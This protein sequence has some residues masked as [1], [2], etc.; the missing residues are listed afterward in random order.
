[1]KRLL[2]WFFILMIV[3]LAGFGGWLYL[4]LGRS[5]KGYTAAEQFV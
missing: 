4:G 3:A 1:V 2:G 5:Y